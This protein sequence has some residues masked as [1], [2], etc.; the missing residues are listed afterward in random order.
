VIEHLAVALTAAVITAAVVPLVRRLAHRLGAVDAPHDPRKI[1]REPV[2]TLG[3]LA[4]FAGFLAAMGVA[5]VLPG[6]DPLFGSTS[7]P[8]ALLVGATLIVLIGM[9]DDLIGLAPTVKLAGQIVAALGLVIFGIQLVHF[10]V[11]GLE[12]IAL[13]ADLGLPLTIVAIV[14]MINALNLIDGLDGLAAGVAMI[15]AVA[16]YLFTVRSQPSGLAETIPTSATLVAA[17]VAGMSA[18]FL[19]HNWHP[20]RIFMGDTG[21]MLLG[22]LL[23]AAGVTY[24]GRTTAPSNTDFYGSVP[25]LVPALVLAIPFLDSAFAVAR[26]AVTRKPLAMADK[27]HLHHL[28]LAFGHSHRR[29]VLVL[30]YWSAVLAFGSVGPAFLPMTRLVPWL[31]VAGALGVALTALGTRPVGPPDVA[32][33]ETEP[34]RAGTA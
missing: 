14:A 10:W 8:M 25:L 2:P 22:L 20:A 12:V 4:M 34:H 7:E 19:V 6:F 11:P 24:V 5:W 33:D 32:V 31:L 17:V 23:G 3:G 28:L 9:A 27:G 15:A 21:S 30:Y 13:S 1:H 29:A 26:R 16:F 18:G